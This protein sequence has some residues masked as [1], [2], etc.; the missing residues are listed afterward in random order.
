VAAVTGA[1]LPVIFDLFQRQPPGL[2]QWLGFG[3][4]LLGI[5]LVTQTSASAAHLRTRGLGL[6]VAAGISFGGFF[7]LL[8]QVGPGAVFAP[9][10]FSRM[11]TLALA[12]VLV[13]LR[14]ERLP[15]PRDNP[16]GLLAG[17]LDAGGNTFYLI[18]I[19]LTRLD[20]AAVLSSLYPAVTVLLAAWL[21]HEKL[22]RLQWAGLAAC[23]MAVMLIVS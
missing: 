7:I 5:W 23:L 21:L 9:L 10:F 6:G 12:L 17:L 18:A 22:T 13:W 2:R 11:A 14:R 4:A 20:I 16:L 3:L 19:Q 8:D 1:L 15:A